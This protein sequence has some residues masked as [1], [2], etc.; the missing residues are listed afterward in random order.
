MWSNQSTDAMYFA[1]HVDGANDST[2]QSV[3]QANQ[4]PGEADDHIN[5]KSL[6][7]DGTGRVYAAVK[8]SLTASNAPLIMLLVR[9]PS[10]GDWTKSVFGRVS[11]GFTRPVVMLDT[12]C[13]AG[14]H[15]RHG[16]DDERDDLREDGVID[17]PTFVTGLGTVFMKDAA[18]S[19][20]NNVTSTKQNV[21]SSTGLVMLAGNESASRYWWNVD[22]LGG[23]PRPT[24]PSDPDPET[25]RPRRPRRRRRPDPPSR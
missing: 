16:A 11:D 15:V 4:G 6:Q 9:D 18:S 14:A 2:W 25:C 19:H 12:D 21:N 24:A 1:T 5:L 23:G 8:T 10:T 13:A 22:P 17:N 20:L 3:K 7:S